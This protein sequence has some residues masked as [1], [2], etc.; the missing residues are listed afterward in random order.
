MGKDKWRNITL[1]MPTFALEM[2]IVLGLQIS[3]GHGVLAANVLVLLQEVKIHSTLEHEISC[4]KLHQLL[5]L[6][7]FIN[8]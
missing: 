6:A 2:C 5:P 3:D 8:L 4:M 7:H 1:Q